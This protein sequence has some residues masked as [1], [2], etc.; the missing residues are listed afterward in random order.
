MPT[1]NPK[2]EKKEEKKP[3]EKNKSEQLHSVKGM[4]DLLDTNYF[5]YQGFFEKAS[6]IALYY[7]FNPIETPV[8]EKEELFTS[9]LGETTDV[10]QK[11]MYSLKTKGGDH[12]A[13]RPEGTAPIM[14]SYLE[15]GMQS[16]PQ[17]V[18]L[19]YYGP[20]FRHDNPQRGR[21][22]EFR[23]FGLEVIGTEKSIADALIIKV[24]LTI[25]EEAGYEK[26]S[27]DVN[28]LGDK[29]CRASY[30]KELINYFKKHAAKLT[31]AQK[32]QMRDNPFR[33]LDSKDPNL[34]EIKA[35]APEVIHHL[36]GPAKQ[37]FKEVL[38]YLE[39]MGV[40]YRINNALVRGLDYYSRTVFE[41][42]E[43]AKEEGVAPLA[44]A[45]GGRYDY[46]G[47]QLGSRKPNPAVGGAIGVDR[48]IE[49]GFAEHLSPRILKK[50]KVFFIQFGFEAKLKSLPI[51]EAM[52]KAKIP[53]RQS[54]SKDS[55][56][57][58]LSQ[59][60]RMGV[61]W[62]V[63]LGQREVIENTV[64]V[65]NMENRSQDVVAV[66]ELSDYIKKKIVAK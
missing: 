17:P 55:L 47:K 10:I 1:N 54:L 59:A 29:E 46:L 64:I 19:Y 25:L 21:F 22:R 11:E 7:G 38:K 58:Q 14:R 23:Q 65:R 50:P 51:I 60:E 32:D 12:L 24:L 33:L 44:I 6:E 49:G 8:L 36:S 43:P 27:V 41:I 2:E 13:L 31:P 3:K 39:S 62:V 15:H 35:G 37:H 9:G 48:I 45:S 18:L 28:S 56:S 61:P 16:L 40:D 20:F 30:R 63:I 57:A 4:R 26:L 53:L 52:R 42:F 5:R 66:A 34:A